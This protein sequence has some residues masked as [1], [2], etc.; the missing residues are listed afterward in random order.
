M[1]IM[2]EL[3]SEKKSCFKTVNKDLILCLEPHQKTSNIA[4]ML[5]KDCIKSSVEQAKQ[6]HTG[7]SKRG[8]LGCFCI[9]LTSRGSGWYDSA[10]CESELIRGSCWEP[11]EVIFCFSL[12]LSTCFKVREVNQLLWNLPVLTSCAYDEFRMPAVN[13]QPLFSTNDQ[14]MF[15]LACKDTPARISLQAGPY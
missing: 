1:Q 13:S 7:E 11:R 5:Q 6:Q 4:P 8:S 10:V 14:I 3:R 9:S 2:H 12:S 15:Y